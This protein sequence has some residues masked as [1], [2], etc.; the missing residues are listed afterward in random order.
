MQTNHNGFTKRAKQHQ[1]R[2]DE[3]QQARYDKRKPWQR[4]DKR[5]PLQ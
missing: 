5:G 1:P 4:Q 2:R 3:E